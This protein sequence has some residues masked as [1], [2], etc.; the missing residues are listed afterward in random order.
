LI[1][2]EIR[3]R[4]SGKIIGLT[5]KEFWSIGTT[6]LAREKEIRGTKHCGQKVNGSIKKTILKWISKA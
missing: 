4:Q 1:K 3:F 5:T 2:S 6:I